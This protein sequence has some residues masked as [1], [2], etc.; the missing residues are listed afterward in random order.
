VEADVLKVNELT[1]NIYMRP[2]REL[3]A[4]AS[5]QTVL[6]DVRE[7]IHVTCIERC[8]RLFS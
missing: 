3:A 7:C 4:C 5:R 8:D 2:C 6:S 1:A